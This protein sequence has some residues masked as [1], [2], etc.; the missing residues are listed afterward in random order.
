MNVLCTDKTGTL[1]RGVV[2]LEGAYDNQ[3]GDPRR[4]WSWPRATA[5]ALLYVAA[6]ELLKD[7]SMVFGTSLCTEFK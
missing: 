7:G 6:T 2:R 1:M 5:V 4:C 3:G